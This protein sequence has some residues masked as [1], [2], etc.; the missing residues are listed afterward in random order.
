MLWYFDKRGPREFRWGWETAG[1]GGRE[2]GGRGEGCGRGGRPFF[3]D[4]ASDE[5]SRE[6]TTEP[7]TRTLRKL[8]P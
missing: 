7:R 8:V 4:G 1:C 2:G 6:R 3:F 5:G